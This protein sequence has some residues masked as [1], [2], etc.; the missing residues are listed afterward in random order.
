MNLG[1]CREG[2]KNKLH[3]ELKWDLGIDGNKKGHDVRTKNYV[4]R[5]EGE[6]IS[7]NQTVDSVSFPQILSSGDR[8]DPPMRLFHA[9]FSP[10]S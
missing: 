9:A 4:E 10:A 1:L 3:Q 8:V 2:G 6:I 7:A 5:L